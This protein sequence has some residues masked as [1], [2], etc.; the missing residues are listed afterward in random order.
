MFNTWVPLNTIPQYAWG[1]AGLCSAYISRPLTGTWEN[2]RQGEEGGIEY[3]AEE[4]VTPWDITNYQRSTFLLDNT[5]GM[6]KNTQRNKTRISEDIHRRK[7][8]G[9]GRVIGLRE[10]SCHTLGASGYNPHKG[11]SG[12]GMN[13]KLPQNITILIRVWNA[14]ATGVWNVCTTLI[15]SYM[16]DSTLGLWN[17]HNPQF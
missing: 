3:Q 6:I 2:S 14:W 4:E 15:L 7:N 16:A 17:L 11:G 9:N 8:G 10:A 5:T 12:I 13:R 1:L